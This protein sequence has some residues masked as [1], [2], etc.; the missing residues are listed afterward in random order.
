MDEQRVQAY[1]SLIQE[2]LT[3]ASGEEFNLLSENAELV[4][5]DLVQVM[6]AEAEKM[7]EQ[8]EGNADWL[9]DFAKRIELVNYSLPQLQIKLTAD[10]LLQQGSQQYQHSE[11]DLAWQSF[12]EC[13]KLYE[14]IG[15]QANIALSWGM[16]GCIQR[17][18]GNWDEAERLYRQSLQL[19]TELGDRSGMAS[20]WELLGDIE[21]NR[22][23]WDEAERLYR[24]CL[25]IETELG[26]RSGMASSWGR[27]GD[28]ERN[29]GNW[30]KAERLYRQCLE[31]ETELGD[32]SGMASSWGRLGDIERNRGNWDEVERLYRQYLEVMTE[33]GDRSG[34]ASCWAS[35]GDIERKR[36]NW[37]EAERLFRQSL[38]L[39]T[40][41]GDRSGMANS[42]GLLG[43][44]ERNRG[45]WDEAERLY[46]QCLEIETELG[47]RSG[48]A[49]SWGVLG[50]IERKRGNWDETERLFRQSLQLRRELG[51]RSGIASC[52]GVLGDIERKRGNWDET[53]RLYRQS[54]QLRTELGDR[55]G[56]ASCWG[57]LGDIEK[58]RGNWDE[59]FAAWR[60]GLEI[61]PPSQ[62][63]LEALKLG[64]NLGDAAFD[65]QDW[66]TAIEG[67]EAA[68]AAVET[69]CSFTDS[70]QEKQKRRTA[71]LDIY[72]KLVQTCIKAGDFGKALASVERSK[73]RNLIELLSNLELYPKGDIPSE[74]LKELDRLR[75]SVSAK[76]RL[77]ESLD[78][79]P[80][81]Q[82]NTGQ[83]DPEP[84]FTR[85]TGGISLDNNSSG[86]NT[87][88]I[89]NL[90][91]NYA[92]DQ[93]ALNQLF[94]VLKKYDPDFILTQQVLSIQFNQIQAL[95]DK[96][97]VLIEW[98]IT[99]EAIYTFLVLGDS[100]CPLKALAEPLF[101]TGAN[102]IYVHISSPEQSQQLQALNQNYFNS[103]QNKDQSLDW[104]K[105]LKQFLQQLRDILELPQLLAPIPDQ[106]HRL[107]LVPYRDLHLFP[108]H[109]LPLD[110]SDDQPTYLADR[111]PQGITYTPSCQFLQVS[112]RNIKTSTSKNLFAIQNPTEDLEYS[113][114][115]VEA[116][117]PN[118]TN[119]AH[120]LIRQDA[121]KTNLQQNPHQQ[122]LQ[123]ADYLHFAGHGTFDFQNPL[124]SSL[125]LAGGKV[126]L[127]TSEIN[128]L[129]N[130]TIPTQATQE[131]PR[132]IPW[133]KDSGI[134]L[135]LTQCYT[136][137]ELFELYLPA[138]R[139]VILS[140]CETG[141]TDFSPD[142]EKYISEEYISLGLGFLYAGATNVICSLWA[143][144]DA[145]T[146]IFMVKFYE[147]MQNQPSIAL[148]LKET[149]YWMR[150]VTK[151][152][153]TE[154]LEDYSLQSQTDTALPATSQVR[155]QLRENLKLGV[156]GSHERPYEHPIHWAAFCAIGI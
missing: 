73:S 33:L 84:P 58:N 1:L 50:D 154:W 121:S 5:A 75:R 16:L 102:G 57:V 48:M 32:R 13:L 139:L 77:L 106:F 107:I 66:A 143:V 8:G 71:A 7:A 12:Q 98:Y 136:L 74:L 125:V 109:A 137:G 118:F 115:E 126:T 119:T 14:E 68:I 3:C 103:Y 76:Q 100:A 25:E 148:A 105:Q 94:E 53:E 89:N 34:M 83:A 134:G 93:Q 63:P 22:G 28:I 153:L 104:E 147:I 155:S 4:D 117:L 128:N 111:F 142:P 151:Q 135:D 152:Q 85:G 31:I 130:P 6:R 156:L 120:R 91:E 37:D 47:D 24:Q 82:P 131:K 2:L 44:I 97:T 112:R 11:H 70:Y 69:R 101:W 127:N 90:R 113:D 30:D 64:T 15:D 122:N 79:S 52:W 43:D 19:R 149:Q 133:R 86:F 108:L 124:L 10:D 9:E 29:R 92:K 60:A 87:D 99:K 96:Q 49:S 95:L 141:L 116:I 146:A 42:W 145:S 27:L 23:N 61:C 39:R 138:C 88:T 36:G 20:S 46:R 45:N 140:A 81:P 55:S 110:N 80:T 129:N 54:L 72:E 78:N 18:R 67:Y 40:E 150:T 26:D 21:R 132:F 65:N 114:L 51:D 123:V 17:D 62:F 59:V 144:N 35:L 56:I 41:L 38:Q